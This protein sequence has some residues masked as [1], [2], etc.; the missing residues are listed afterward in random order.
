MYGYKKFLIIINEWLEAINKYIL[1][2]KHSTPA[3][4]A[5]DDDLLFVCCMRR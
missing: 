3:K 2:E 1:K 4:Q 5:G